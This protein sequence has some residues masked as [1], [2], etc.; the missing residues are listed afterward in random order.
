MIDYDTT[1]VYRHCPDFEQ[2]E[3]FGKY[4]TPAKLSD[5]P[6]FSGLEKKIIITLKSKEKQNTKEESRLR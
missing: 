2:E 3:P 6:L 5:Y 1:G 4:Q